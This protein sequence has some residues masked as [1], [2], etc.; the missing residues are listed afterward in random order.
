M[1]P[2]RS[3]AG[4]GWRSGSIGGSSSLSTGWPGLGQSI[5]IARLAPRQMPSIR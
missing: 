1:V 3:A 2:R 4:T 5:A